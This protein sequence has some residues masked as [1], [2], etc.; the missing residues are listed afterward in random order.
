MRMTKKL[1]IPLHK[2]L[3]ING[4]TTNPP[5]SKRAVK[6][7]LK[8]LVHDIGM[9]RIGGPFVRYVKAPGNKGLT[10]VVMIETSHIALH[11][12]EEGPNPYFRFDLYTCGPLHHTT[13]LDHVA[14]FLS[15][16]EMEWVAFDREKG[17]LEYD[18]GFRPLH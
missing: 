3:L 5:T 1:K 16:K 2:H 6:K 18:N 7:W 12:W 10:A 15:A 4:K 8:N 11:I 17:F 14:S 13:V 9:H